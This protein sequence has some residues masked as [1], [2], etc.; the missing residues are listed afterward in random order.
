ML[1]ALIGLGIQS[2][3]DAILE[4]PILQGAS[5]GV[6]VMDESGLVRYAR[7]PALRLVPASNQKLLTTAYALQRLGPGYTP[8]TRI[9]K[10]PD[11]VLVDAPG[12]P[13]LTYGDLS[14]ASAKLALQART[15]VFV[16]QAYRVGVPPSWEHDDLPHRYAPRI[17]ALNFDRGAFQLFAER[18]SPI[19]LPESFGVRVMHFPWG[20]RSQEFDPFGNVMVVRGE[21]PESRTFLENFA[22]PQPDRSAASILGGPLLETTTVP[23][24]PPLIAIRGSKVATLV[25]DCLVPSDNFIAEHLLL[26]A[27]GAEGSLG[28]APYDVA[29]AR[30]TRF[31]VET[32]GLNAAD[33]RVVDGSGMS[34]HNLVT[35]RAIAALLTWAGK[36][37]F[38][39]LWKASLASPGTGTLSSRLAAS[40]FRGK[41]GSLDMVSSLSGYVTSASGKTYAVSLLMNH[42]LGGAATVRGIQD[43]FVR[44]VEKGA[45]D[46]TVIELERRRENRFPNANPRRAHGDRL[47]RPFAHSH[48]ALLWTDN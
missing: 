34:R 47:R 13:S 35:A 8:E 36:Q 12:N 11:R 10:L 33:L 44:E 3:L 23:A 20:T 37:P 5:V 30:M 25:K 22:I 2:S 21:L 26:M 1:L 24:S 14:S 41:T 38:A 4:V 15:P 16:K 39:E 28:K 48:P 40:S 27:G 29:P 9:W 32:V 31:L 18:G 7:N 43:Q 42:F 19:L 45:L 6:V 46:G 17:T